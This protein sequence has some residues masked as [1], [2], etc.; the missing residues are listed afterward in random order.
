MQLPKHNLH[1]VAAVPETSPLGPLAPPPGTDK[2]PGWEGKGEISQAIGQGSGTGPLHT[3][4]P[5]VWG[6]WQEF[7]RV[8]HS[9]SDTPTDEDWALGAGQE[10]G[11]GGREREALAQGAVKKVGQVFLGLWRNSCY[12]FIM[13]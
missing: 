9:A 5:P 11:G 8:A 1:H 3:G 13:A 6:P 10:T 12:K 7:R 4:E 2:E